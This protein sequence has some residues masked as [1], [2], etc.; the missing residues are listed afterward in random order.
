EKLIGVFA[1]YPSKLVRWPRPLYQPLQEHFN[2]AIS[3][4]HHRLTLLKLVALLHDIAK[5]ETKSSEPDGRIRFLCHQLLGAEAAAVVMK[6]LRFSNQEVD[7][8]RTV[9]A[10]HLRPRQLLD[11]AGLTGRAVYRFFRDTGPEGLDTLVLSLAD[12]LAT[13]G[14]ALDRAAWDKHVALTVDLFRK[15]LAEKE[16][17]V[18]PPR[19]L[20]G[21]DIMA[22]LGLEPGPLIGDLLE[23]VREAQ[24]MG[25]VS[26]RAEALEYVREI[27]A[28]A[29]P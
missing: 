1:G 10:N 8:V 19:L 15:Y 2:E 23:K 12:H 21:N 11:G 5:P 18:S 14:P 17:T 20:D 25:M 7:V 29:S 9:V 13:R 22:V 6:R 26:D 27:M 16:E 4:D 3:A 28:N 24:A